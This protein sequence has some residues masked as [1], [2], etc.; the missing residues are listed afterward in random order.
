MNHDIEG[1]QPA[2][3]HVLLV[4]SSG[5]HLAQLVNLRPW[6]SRLSR[7]W[8]TFNTP[9][10]VGHLADESVV[11][12]YHPTTRSIPNLLRNTVLAWRVI[13]RERPTI[14]LST[15]AGLALPFF[16]IAHLHK[17]LTVYIEVFDRID[18]ATLTGR[19]IGPFTDLMCVQWDEQLKVYPGAKVI[20]PLL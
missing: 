13:R 12:G 7:S 8:V 2:R 6:W 20:G 18:S 14:V 19:L 9:D 1:P 11:W 4:G 3:E 5:G 15:G 16:V 10:A 17:T